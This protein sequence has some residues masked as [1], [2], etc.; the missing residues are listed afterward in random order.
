MSK[1]ANATTIVLGCSNLA[2]RTRTVV[3]TCGNPVV[4]TY[5]DASFA[6]SEMAQARCHQKQ[7]LAVPDRQISLT[8]PDSARGSG[9]VAYN[10]QTAVDTANALIVA[11]R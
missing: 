3:P 9:V 5:H 2:R 10:V 7:V 1:R 11:T 6:K 4:S 8:D